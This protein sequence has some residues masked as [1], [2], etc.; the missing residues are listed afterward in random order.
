MP[1]TINYNPYSI[2]FRLLFNNRLQLNVIAVCNTYLMDHTKLVNYSN[3]HKSGLTRADSLF[4][5]A[6]EEASP[7]ASTETC[8]RSMSIT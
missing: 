5:V 6:D 7:V 1:C 4:H 2:Y 3:I 8:T